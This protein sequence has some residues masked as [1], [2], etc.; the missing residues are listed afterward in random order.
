[1]TEAPSHPFLDELRWR[2]LLHQ[3]TDAAGLVS[4]LA[5]GVRSAY[6]GFDPTADSLTVGNLIAIKLLMHWQRAGQRPIALLGGGTGLIGD[7]SGKSA[8]RQLLSRQ[9]VEHNVAGQQ[10]IFERLLDFGSPGSDRGARLVNNLDWLGGLGYIEVLR[11]VGKHFSVNAMIQRDSVRDRLHN[12]EQGLSYTEFSYMI[13]QAYDFLHQWQHDGVSVQMGGSDQWGNIISGCDLIRRI[14]GGGSGSDPAAA[15]SFG[16]TAPLVTRADGGKFGKSEAGAV[17]LSPERTSP[18]AFYQF[19]LN[20]EDSD[21]VRY[22]KLFTLLGQPEVADLEAAHSRDPGSRP[23]QRALARHMTE[24]LHGP[25]ERA[26]AETAAQVLFSGEVASLSLAT[27]SEAL[28]SVP[29]SSHD[30]SRLAGEGTALVDALVETA[31]CKSKREAREMLVAGSILVNGQRA[32]SDDRLT[33]SS[34]LHGTLIALRRGKK[35]WHLLRFA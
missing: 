3:V 6:V 4:H 20:T 14:G 33:S 1:M 22:L 7:P 23:A 31:L 9:Q 17:W 10:R 12:R 29:T 19:W 34:L 26:Q 30:R 28:A 15:H 2:G 21:V 8:E 13:L 5:T 16:L 24:L 18:Y 25:T 11:D 35:S 32:G 27:L